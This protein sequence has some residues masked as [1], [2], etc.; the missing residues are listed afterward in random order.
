MSQLS[1]EED[2]QAAADLFETVLS[3]AGLP[4]R[5]GIVVTEEP[6][7]LFAVQPWSFVV[8]LVVWVPSIAV[9]DRELA[10]PLPVGV[11]IHFVDVDVTTL[12]QWDHIGDAI[13]GIVAVDMMQGECVLVPRS[14]RGIK[15]RFRKPD[16]DQTLIAPRSKHGLP[17]VA[18][19][20][21]RTSWLARRVGQ[22][23]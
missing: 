21:Y 12:R 23:W 1:T 13:V 7:G 4:L 6:P 9:F 5:L 3:Y 18:V 22:S 2:P 16:T 10:V 20:H 19:A 15:P 11:L 17:E 8:L 14:R